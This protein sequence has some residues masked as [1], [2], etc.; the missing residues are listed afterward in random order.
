MLCIFL[1]CDGVEVSMNITFCSRECVSKYCECN[2]T[3]ENMEHNNETE[4]DE[5]NMKIMVL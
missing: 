4:H 2:N 3:E 5:N 1:E